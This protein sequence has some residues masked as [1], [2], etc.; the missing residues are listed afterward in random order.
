MPRTPKNRHKGAKGWWLVGGVSVI[1]ILAV[2]IAVSARSGSATTYVGPLATGDS[3]NPLD[4]PVALY[5]GRD[6]LGANSL[7]LSSLLGK[8]PIILNYWASN[9]APCS[10]EMPEFE[11]VWKQYGDRVLFFGLDVGGFAG[12]GGP[13]ESKKELQRLGVTY[14]AAPVPNI[15]VIRDLQVKGLPST[16]FIS[17]DGTVQKNWTGSLNRAK[18]TQLVEELLSVS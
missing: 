10:A 17:P 3:A 8:K 14:P 13:E 4:F 15:N 18:L 1:A 6:I 9:C 7:Q 2:A 16:D 11:Q 5:Q 12:F